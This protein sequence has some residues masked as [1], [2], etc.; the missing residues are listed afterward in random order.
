MPGGEIVHARVVRGEI[1][2]DKLDE[3]IRPWQESVGPSAKR[4]SGFKGAQLMVDRNAGKVLSIGLWE[5]KPEV[6]ESVGWNQEQISKFAGLFSGPP[7][8]E[9]GYELAAEG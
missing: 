4:Q 2:T 3:A 6:R 9:E 1:P 8:I 7:T 5:S